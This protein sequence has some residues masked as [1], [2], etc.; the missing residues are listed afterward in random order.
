MSDVQELKKKMGIHGNATCSISLDNSVG[1]LLGEEN[2]GL[3]GMFLMMNEARFAC[4]IQALGQCATSYA[5]AVKYAKDRIQSPAI[6]EM[7]NPEANSVSIVQH[8]DVR[9]QLLFMKSYVEGIRG[10]IYYCANCFQMSE[11]DSLSKEEKDKYKGLCELLTPV[12][13]AYSTDKSFDVCVQGIQVFGG[14]GYITEYP[15]EQLMRDC[16]I[17]SVY[18]GTN[19]VQA[20]DLLGRKLGMKKGKPFMDLLGEISLTIAK[21]KEFD[22]LQGIAKDLERAS[23]SLGA[24][25]MHIGQVAM[26]EKILNAFGAASDFLEVTGDVVMAWIHLLRAHTAKNI[27]ENGKVKK[28]DIAFY[29][30]QIFTAKYFIESIL[31]CAVGKM[32]SVENTTSS[33]MEIPEEAFI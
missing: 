8:P 32:K 1:Y 3:K 33:I 2:K 29:E 4:G 6:L 5:N 16:K 9:R 26:S 17:T 13:K 22:E 7:L 11:M 18:E 27:L 24:T 20:M 25:A 12:V 30:G 28:K 23:G 10:L 15:Q 19:G 14:Y 31:P 21:A